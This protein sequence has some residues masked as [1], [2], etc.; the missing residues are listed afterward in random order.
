MS[1][2]KGKVPASLHAK[3]EIYNINH[4]IEILS[5][6]CVIEYAD[7]IGS[8]WQAVGTIIAQSVAQQ[9]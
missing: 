9:G 1:D 8:S 5:E 4:A 7:I 6:A 2:W 3:Y